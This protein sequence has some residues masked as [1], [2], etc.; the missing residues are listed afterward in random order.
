MRTFYIA[1][2]LLYVLFLLLLGN[3]DIFAN[4]YMQMVFYVLDA[5]FVAIGLVLLDAT[6]PRT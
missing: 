2:G 5:V 6:R 3:D 1:T 4:Q